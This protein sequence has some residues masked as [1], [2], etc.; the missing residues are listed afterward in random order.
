MTTLLPGRLGVGI[1]GA[2]R[3]AV[4]L[5]KAMSTVPG[6]RL[7]T[8]A[9]PDGGAAAALARVYG[10]TVSADAA[11][12]LGDDSVDVMVVATPPDTHADI[13]CAALTAGRHVFCEKPMATGV[14]SATRVAE[15]AEATDR[16]VVLDHVLRYNPLLAA[17]VMLQDEL[18]GPVQR[19]SFENDA[20]DENLPPGHWFWDSPRSG[21]VFVEHGVHFF[22]AAHLLLGTGPLTVAAVQARRPDG[23]TD[24]VSATALHP[25]GVL[26][27]HTHAFAH[28]DRCERQRMH[29]DHGAAHVVVEGWIPVRARIDAWTNDRGAEL[30]VGLPGRTSPLFDVPGHRIA[31]GARIEVAVA[32]N[33]GAPTA[34]SRGRDLLLPHHV[35]IDID[36]GDHG[37]S[38]E[39]T[40][41]RVYAESVR[42]A[43]F[44]LV[45]CATEGGLPRS[46]VREGLAAVAVADAAR[47]AAVEGRHTMPIRPAST[48]VSKS[49]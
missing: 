25:G 37:E 17:L 11:A 34:T 43:F 13:S 5:T 8:V 2:G 6:L 46:G 31:P 23:S 4:F 28:P 44:D 16:V 32:R 14:D 47:R 26:A 7:V 27:T 48:T 15:A 36:L 38:T 3:F 33:A 42:A 9:D 22:D 41:T 35:G 21:G 29:L 49:A 12:V 20:S 1:V 10:A 30:A 40:K 18:L 19:F 24:I 39:E 45:R